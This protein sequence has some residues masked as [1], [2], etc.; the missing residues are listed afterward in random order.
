MAYVEKKSSSLGIAQMTSS[1]QDQKAATPVQPE[2]QAAASS[3]TAVSAWIIILAYLIVAIGSWVGFMIATKWVNPTPIILESIEGLSLFAIFYILAA[4]TERLVEPLKS[5][6]FGAKKKDAENKRD[7]GKAS[8]NI[9]QAADGQAEVNQTRGETRIITW[10]LATLFAIIGTSSTGILFLHAI[11]AE[12]FPIWLDVMITGLIIGAGSKPLHDL[13]GYI[14][15]K[16]IGETD[17]SNVA[18]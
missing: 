1:T 14:E 10:A 3:E 6:L 11:G 5:L 16:S 4:A 13:I 17:E 12:S 7:H 2:V 8:G 9:Q 15:K 18:A